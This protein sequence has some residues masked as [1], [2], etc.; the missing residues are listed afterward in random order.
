MSSPSVTLITGGCR[1]GK[2]RRALMLA[3]SY[4]HPVF[5]ATAEAGDDEMR[6]RIA[7]HRAERSAAFKT[8]EEPLAP[9]AVFS[10]LPDGTDLVLVDCI[11]VWLSNLI[12]HYRE[13]AEERLEIK[14]F[15]QLLKTPPCDVILVTNETGTGI[16][17]MNPVARQF[18][19]LAG[20]VN[21]KLA[22]CA[23]NVEM[24]VCGISMQLKG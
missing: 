16:V 8:V 7:K 11:T 6:A 2:S 17:P 1:S 14:D 3:A 23:D 20:F 24:T 4:R 5:L 10:S 12:H 13:E 9:A 18:R 21:Q 22:A 19:D 15:L